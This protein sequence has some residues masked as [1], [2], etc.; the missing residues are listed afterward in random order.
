MGLTTN[1]VMGIILPYMVSLVGLVMFVA[2]LV[3][4]LLWGRVFC[5]SGCPL[6]AIQHLIYK[7]KKSYKLPIKIS[8]YLKIMPIL[9]LFATV[10]FS[11]TGTIYLGCELDPYKP[12]F[13]TG[14]AWF[15]QGIALLTGFPMEHK[16][17]LSFGILGWIYLFITLALGYWVERPFCRL[18][19]PYSAILGLFSLVSLKPRTI[20]KAKCTSCNLCVKACPTQAITISKK[21]EIQKVSNYDC[22]Q[23]NRC[24]DRCKQDAIGL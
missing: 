14:K 22:I 7:K 5:T 9:I 23:C 10:Y 2:P 6:G 17:L 15:E 1:V 13:F 3:I 21:E 19:C 4:A 11:I 8:R 20:D 18:L 16:L 12:I 24:S